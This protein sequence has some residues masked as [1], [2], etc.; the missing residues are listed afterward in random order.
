MD[1][2]LIM[3]SSASF[4]LPFFFNKMNMDKVLELQ[5]KT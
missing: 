3:N 4:A 5:N 2:H 1:S